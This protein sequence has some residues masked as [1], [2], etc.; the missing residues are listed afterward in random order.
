M[1]GNRVAQE[2]GQSSRAQPTRL[3]LVAVQHE[4]DWHADTDSA[5]LS[6]I[7]ES[8]NADRMYHVS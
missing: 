3:N 6:L 4:R 2:Q 1:Y 5:Y 8:K 7:L